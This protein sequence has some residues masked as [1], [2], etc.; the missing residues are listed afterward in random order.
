MLTR[1]LLFKEGRTDTTRSYG[2]YYLLLV[3]LM[4]LPFLGLECNFP[5]FM[6]YFVNVLELLYLRKSQGTHFII[7]TN[8]GAFLLGFDDEINF[9]V[10][11]W[12]LIYLFFS[13]SLSSCTC[14]LHNA[15]ITTSLRL[16]RVLLT[17]ISSSSQNCR[18]IS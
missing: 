18:T 3:N 7:K 17:S 4:L 16:M 1:G 2:S 12:K 14:L 15:I 10:F 5:S 6:F 8:Y 9:Y 13:L 11:G